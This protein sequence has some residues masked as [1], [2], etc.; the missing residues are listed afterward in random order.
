MGTQN[1]HR[2]S[3][4]KSV[5]LNPFS[6]TPL[7]YYYYPQSAKPLG[8][9]RTFLSYRGFFFFVGGGGGGGGK[10]RGQK[11]DFLPRTME[12]SQKVSKM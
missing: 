7:Y 10:G 6:A 3:F 12:I 9:L 11:T 4:L 5:S 2:V 8:S 1:G